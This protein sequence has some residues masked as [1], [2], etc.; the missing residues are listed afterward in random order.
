M[1]ETKLPVTSEDAFTCIHKFCQRERHV[2]GNQL[3]SQGSFTE[4]KSIRWGRE[5]AWEVVKAI[6]YTSGKKGD[7]SMYESP[8]MLREMGQRFHM[9]TQPIL[10]SAL[11]K[12]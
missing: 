7:I 2:Q 6:I 3:S 10:A 4:K 11:K 5:E 8:A 12:K 9:L 1:D